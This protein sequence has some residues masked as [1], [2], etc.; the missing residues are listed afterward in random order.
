NASKVPT[1]PT[2]EQLAALVRCAA[3]DDPVFATVI[4]L[5][6]ATGAR[7]GELAALRWSDVDLVAGTITIS[8][9]LTVT[10]R[11]A[12]NNLHIGPTKTRQQ[13]RIT[14][15]DRGVELLSEHWRSIL[16]LSERVGS[17]LAE[18]PYL[19][20]RPYQVNGAEPCLPDTWTTKFSVLCERAGVGHFRFHDLR[21]WNAT[22]L[23]GAGHDVRTVSGRLG[24]AQTSMTL[25]KYA[26]ALPAGDAAAAAVIGA[27]LPE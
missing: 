17:P 20:A 27:L 12:D 26:H 16:V 25:D 4:L 3:K 18:D 19:F 7:R 10:G 23:I 5:A 11:R 2:V 9:S 15:G 22:Q 24:H 8:K 1:V 21:H 14:L 6:A 13:R